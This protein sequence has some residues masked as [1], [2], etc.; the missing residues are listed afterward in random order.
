MH[1]VIVGCWEIVSHI[2]QS[3]AASST[4]SLA[5]DLHEYICSEFVLVKVLEWTDP[6][7]GN[8]E[9]FSFVSSWCRYRAGCWLFLPSS[10]LCWSLYHSFVLLSWLEIGGEYENMIVWSSEDFQWNSAP[11]CLIKKKLRI[12]RSLLLP[13]RLLFNLALFL[14][15]RKTQLYQSVQHLR[16]P[17]T[18]L[19]TGTES[20]HPDHLPE[21][22]ERIVQEGTGSWKNGSTTTICCAPWVWMIEVSTGNSDRSTIVSPISLW[23]RWWGFLTV[24]QIG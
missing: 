4:Q 3:F 16:G 15:V 8:I 2:F 13:I 23:V 12:T 17:S 22:M 11:L 10:V 24:F 19:T 9:Q 7:N 21:D 18:N 20:V 5:I 14:W 6:K 1:M